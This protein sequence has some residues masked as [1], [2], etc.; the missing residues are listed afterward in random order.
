M[1]YKQAL[2]GN[3]KT[4]EGRKTMKKVTFKEEPKCSGS[5]NYE[6][7]LSQTRA[8][9]EGGSQLDPTGQPVDHRCVL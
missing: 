8:R 7:I 6:H 9:Q 4:T 1:N 3:Q 5:V 2:L